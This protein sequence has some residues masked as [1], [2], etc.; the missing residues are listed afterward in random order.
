LQARSSQQRRHQHT[1]MHTYI[2]I[3]VTGRLE[4][5]SKSEQ[6]RHQQISSRQS[7]LCTSFK[8]R[9]GKSSCLHACMFGM[10]AN[11]MPVML[12][13]DKLQDTHTVYHMVAILCM[14]YRARLPIVIRTHYHLLTILSNSY[15]KSANIDTHTLSHTWRPYFLYI[16]EHSCM[17]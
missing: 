5:H 1:C 3:T 7:R 12:C 11:I 14:Y 8:T 15:S 6:R 2:C 17:W 9:K 10:H 16:A 4:A 13:M